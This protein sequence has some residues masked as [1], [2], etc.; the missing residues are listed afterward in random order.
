[1]SRVGIVTDS[2]A[3]IPAELAAERRIEIVPL[4]LAFGERIYLDGMSSDTA[5]FYETLRT[6]RQAPTTAA[7]PPGVYAEAI[8]R[9]GKDADAVLCLTVS[10]QFSAMYEAAV[11]GAAL[12]SEQEPSLDVRVL[13]SG[14]AAMA[15]GFVVLEA[16]RAAAEGAAIEQLIARAEALM[17]RVQLLVALD[18]LA[19]LA[20]SGR[21]P[22]LIIW[23]A[24]P[25]RIK[26][27]VQFQKGKY[28]PI[29]IVRTMRG[30]VERLLQAL[31]R[32]TEGGVLHVC[33]HH[34]NVPQEAEALAERVR[35]TLQP[36]ELLIAEF[37]QVMGVHT[38]P[39][40]LGFAFYTE[41]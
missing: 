31:T 3:C 28:R 36:K 22:R 30:G 20:H 9:A 2:T 29:A 38:G 6:T 16:E 5:E 26:P 10:R 35:D 7:P 32:R 40:L 12:V 33:V 25:L 13:D 21:V 8:L 23:A 17:P 34:T 41:P 24:S 11:Q 18:T 27:I 19:Y 39:G 15:Q 1:M 37:N 4:Y 14:A